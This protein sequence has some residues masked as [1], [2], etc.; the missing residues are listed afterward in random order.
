MKR[1]FLLLLLAPLALPAQDLSKSPWH[2]QATHIDP[3]NY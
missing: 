2:V 3:N 1:L